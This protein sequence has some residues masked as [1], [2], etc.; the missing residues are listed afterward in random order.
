MANRRIFQSNRGPLP[1][2]ADAANEEFAPAYE[3]PPRDALA[4]YAVTGCLNGTFYAS[5]AAQL[6]FVLRLCAQAAVAFIAKCALYSRRKGKLKDMPALLLAVL[7]VR[8]PQLLARVFHRVIDNAK[9]LRNFVQIM[10]SGRAGRKSLGTVPR[11]LVREWLDRRSDEEIFRGAVGNNPSMADIIKM[12]HP[13]P[14]TA[15]RAALYAYLL[16]KPH[17]AAQLP[18]LVREY[19]AFR[20]G[21][22]SET[23][24]VPFE[25][26]T[27]VDL[28]VEQWRQ[29]ARR[30]PWQVTRINLLTF[31]R[32]G[33]FRDTEVTSLIAGRLRDCQQIA[34][35]RALPYQMMVSLMMA[36]T[37]VP[38]IVREALDAALDNAIQNVPELPGKV[39]ILPDVSSSMQSPL[40][41]FRKGATSA[42]RC[43]DVAA[44]FTAAILR[45]NPSAE[46]LAFDDEVYNVRMNPRDTVMTNAEKL[47][48][49]GG[50]G[51]NCSAPL[52]ELNR[53]RAKGDLLIYITDE[54]SW[55]DD[56]QDDDDDTVEVDEETALQR[57]WRTFQGWRHMWGLGQRHPGSLKELWP[58]FLEWEDMWGARHMSKPVRGPTGLQKLWHAFRQRNAGARLVCIDLQPYAT[59]Q[60][61]PAPDVLHVGGFSDAV[62]DVI[63][64]FARGELQGDHWTKIIEEEEL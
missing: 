6:E 51:T 3:L 55:L 59:V 19:E 42:V 54:Q 58:A 40:T 41:G 7:S 36:G 27:A 30:A 15:S 61:K 11:R 64:M 12:V 21:T 8:D 23:P 53:R 62:F 20:R 46:V 63:A 56:L 24:D 60:A 52:I 16:D 44:L 26:L 37:A 48:A 22:S 43:V 31:A 17:D 50:G 33:V 4:Q 29:I 25:M 13:K 38:I 14:R 45:R 10:R 18:P 39:L 2:V 5:G 47:G 9:M 35:G 34:R 1:P 28:T 57:R 49:I 32:H